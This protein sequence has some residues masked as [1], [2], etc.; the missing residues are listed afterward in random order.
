MRFIAL[1]LVIALAPVQDP[2]RITLDR[3]AKFSE[4]C[5]SFEK[6][7]GG[8]I[9]AD[10]EVED[11]EIKLSLKDASFFE[12]VDALCRAHG[13]ASYVDL[14]DSFGSDGLELR[15]KPLPWV[16]YPSAYPGRFKV[17][18]IA[19][20]RFTCRQ[21]AGDRQWTRLHLLVFGP[22][23]IPIDHSS[24][25]TCEWTMAKALDAD[26]K[27]VLLGE[28]E[29]PSEPMVDICSTPYV[30][31][32]VDG[33]AAVLKPFDLDRGLK[34]AAGTLKLTT[35]DPVDLRVPLEVGKEVEMPGGTITVDAVREHEKK[36]AR[37]ATWRI[38]LTLKPKAKAA[39]IGALLEQRVRCGVD[40]D[41]SG[42]RYQSYPPSGMTFEVQAGPLANAPTW[43]RLRVRT[44][45]RTIDVPFELKD[46]VFKKE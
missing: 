11:K 46:I 4:F 14:S 44:N 7:A 13:S 21:D 10:D 36:G 9:A 20:A 31:G 18:A 35:A 16:E 22:P 3:T 43:V 8:K 2:S 33:Y 27:D 39:S 38:H 34:V 23:G 37:G 26:G 6:A 5:A 42:W 32:N 45:P 24:G 1:A 29:A 40:K 41:D 19:M 17:A 12:A 25:A 30:E 28:K 15:I